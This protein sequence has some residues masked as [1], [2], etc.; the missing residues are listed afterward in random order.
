MFISY[1]LQVPPA[2]ASLLAPA[3][4]LLQVVDEQ[5]S[6]DFNQ[7]LDK[8]NTRNDVQDPDSV[9][10]GDWRNSCHWRSWSS[11][12]GRRGWFRR[13]WSGNRC[14]S[15]HHSICICVFVYA[16]LSFCICLLYLQMYLFLA[17]AGVAAGAAGA[18]AG[19]GATG[20]LVSLLAGTSALII[21]PTSENTEM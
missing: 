19:A 5:H 17:G 15:R 3:L 14:W 4:S 9:V 12:W 1:V 10:K 13:S 11:H 6:S 18:G 16:Y 7:N 20:Y 21:L 2:I 8:K